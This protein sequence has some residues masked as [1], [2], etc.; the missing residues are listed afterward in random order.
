MEPRQ[1]RLPGF[2][3]LWGTPCLAC[4]FAA[5]CAT[6]GRT[7]TLAKPFLMPLRLKA[8]DQDNAGFVFGAFSLGDKVRIIRLK[9]GKASLSADRVYIYRTDFDR[10]AWSGVVHAAGEPVF[11]HGPA[12]FETLDDAETDAAAWAGGHGTTELLVE[13]PDT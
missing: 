11:G 1:L 3:R 10:F 2:T 12:E 4:P 5:R 13:V 9:R 8:E 7:C 6:R